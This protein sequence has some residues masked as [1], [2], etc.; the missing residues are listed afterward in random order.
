MAAFVTA[1]RRLLGRPSP[2]SYAAAI[3]HG[4]S[5][6]R[7]SEFLPWQPTWLGKGTANIHQKTSL[8]DL[9]GDVFNTAFRGNFLPFWAHCATHNVRCARLDPAQPDRAYGEQE[10]RDAFR[11]V[12]MQH[13]WKV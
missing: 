4:F 11:R 10:A 9:V 1:G 3:D 2:P 12:A 13:G 6:Q 7:A 8:V 5:L